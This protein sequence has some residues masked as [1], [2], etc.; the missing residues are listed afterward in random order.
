MAK[1]QP[2]LYERDANG[3]LVPCRKILA[4]TRQNVESLFKKPKPVVKKKPH[5]RDVS[6][7][8]LEWMKDRAT[9]HYE[10]LYGRSMTLRPRDREK[11]LTMAKKAADINVGEKVKR[12]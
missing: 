11:M 12:G 3:L 4:A 6:N 1:L 10:K 2:G 5:G 9:E 8:E 7:T